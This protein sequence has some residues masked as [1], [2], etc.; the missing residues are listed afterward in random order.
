MSLFVAL[1]LETLGLGRKAPIIEFGAL[2][3]DWMTGDV[4]STC[5]TYVTHRSYDNCEPFA[6]SMHPA[7]LR[8]IALKELPFNYTPVENIVDYFNMWLVGCRQS[9]PR[10]AMGKLT[11]A[12]KNLGTFDLPS[13]EKQCP[14]WQPW[15]NRNCHHRV[16]D[17][18]NLFWNPAQ[19]DTLPNS[20]TCRE[21]AHIDRDED[22][23][24]NVIADCEDV[25]KMIAVA[26]GRRVSPAT[27]FGELYT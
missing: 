27:L 20:D 4:L 2:L 22:E 3:A 18:G 13:L 5:H 6:M 9:F 7:I 19:D 24:H 14:T 16:L 8:R 15:F 26:V 1:D 25:V 10:L 23:K 11:L 17:P 12:G 21:R